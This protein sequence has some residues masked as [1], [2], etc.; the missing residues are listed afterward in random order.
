[1]HP[2]RLGGKHGAGL[3]G[4]GVPGYGVP[5]CWKTR[6]LVENAGSGGKRGVRWKTRG[7]VE[8]AGYG[9][10]RR[11]WWK[12]RGLMW[13]TRGNTIFRQNIY[14]LSSLKWERKILL[15]KLRWISIQHLRLKSVLRRSKKNK[16]IIS[17]ERK[18]LKCQSA[19]HWFSFGDPLWNVYFIFH[20]NLRVFF[21][22]EKERW[23]CKQPPLVRKPF[24]FWKNPTRI[25]FEPWDFGAF[26]H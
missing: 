24:S 4:C 10:K 25:R 19:V 11:V 9:G 2:K 5:G 23:M 15:A 3:P 13:K 8:N 7:L 21:T 17:W 20:S 12:T 26:R 22:L 1:M 18:P 6:G 16:F 14:A